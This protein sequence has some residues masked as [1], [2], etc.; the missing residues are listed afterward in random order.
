[1]A[2]QSI[3]PA[4][5][6]THAMSGIGEAFLAGTPML[7]ISG[8]VRH[9]TG[10]AFQLHNLDMQLTNDALIAADVNIDYSKHTSFTQKVV[11]AV[12]DRLPLGE[13]AR[14]IGRALWRKVTE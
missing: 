3:V 9:G 1:M 14:F 11:K 12:M 8:G 6:V 7:V 5:G 13:K 4:A 10:R 2:V